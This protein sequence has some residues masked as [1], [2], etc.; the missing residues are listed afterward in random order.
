M[1]G[2]GFELKFVVDKGELV[3]VEIQLL[4]LLVVD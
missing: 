1:V 3:C 2:V 4:D